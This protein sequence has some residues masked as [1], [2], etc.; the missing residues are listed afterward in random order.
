ML[1]IPGIGGDIP[2]VQF[3]IG[4]P[5]SG[6]TFGVVSGVSSSVSELPMV[7]Y[8]MAVGKP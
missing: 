2:N 7:R 1:D 6:V 3:R 8:S 4:G 5:I